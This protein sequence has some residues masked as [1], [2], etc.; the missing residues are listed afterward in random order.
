M[1]SAHPQSSLTL[2]F[3]ILTLLCIAAWGR[4]VLRPV[5]AL[6]PTGEAG[7]SDALYD[8]HTRMHARSLPGNAYRHFLSHD[9]SQLAFLHHM[10]QSC[11]FACC[12]NMPFCVMCVC[13]PFGCILFTVNGRCDGVICDLQFVLRYCNFL[14]LTRPGDAY[15]ELL[16]STDLAM[17]PWLRKFQVS[18]MQLDQHCLLTFVCRQPRV[19]CC[20]YAFIPHAICCL[21]WHPLRCSACVHAYLHSCLWC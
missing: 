10:H 20:V 3:L 15:S 19:L 4:A 7:S 1:F 12:F 13:Q 18:T 16:N 5:H 8:I 2:S 21:R 14:A 6:V 9:N 17:M 11:S